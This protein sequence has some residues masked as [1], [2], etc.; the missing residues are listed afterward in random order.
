MNA[1]A[2]EAKALVVVRA[3]QLAATG[4]TDWEVAVQTGLAKTHI[5]EVLTNSRPTPSHSG[6]TPRY[7]AVHRPPER[8]RT[9]EGVA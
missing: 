3:Y 5:G 4:S 9:A 2:N 7:P 6:S 8:H 1:S